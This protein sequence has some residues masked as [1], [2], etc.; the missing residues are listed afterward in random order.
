MQVLNFARR[1][2]VK[3]IGAN[4]QIAL[5]L[6]NALTWAQANPAAATPDVDALLGQTEAQSIQKEGRFGL[7]A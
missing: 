6:Q 7:A 1:Q 5:D 2:S 3:V 4:G